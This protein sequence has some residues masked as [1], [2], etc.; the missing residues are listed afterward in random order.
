MNL[1]SWFQLEII[2]LIFKILRIFHLGLGVV[3]WARVLLN[4]VFRD[5][6]WGDQDANIFF[7]YS[8]LDF[9]YLLARKV[10]NEFVVEELVDSGRLNLNH[11][12]QVFQEASRD[13]GIGCI[14]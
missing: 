14:E 3:R 11:V 5:E 10:V 6:L 1:H 2:V 8:P 9:L 4:L 12:T 7:V 13:E